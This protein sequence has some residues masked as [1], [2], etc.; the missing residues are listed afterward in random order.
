[1][2]GSLTIGRLL[3][4]YLQGTK[5]LR[6]GL[7]ETVLE[8]GSDGYPWILYESKKRLRGSLVLIHG[9]TAQASEDP[10][11][12]H[13]ARCLA[14]LGY[15]CLTPPLSR[16]AQF[17]HSEQDV[18]VVTLALSRARELAQAPVGV[19]AFSYGASY[20]LSAAARP[21]SRE[22]CRA[23]VAFGAYYLLA[24]ALEHQRQLLLQNPDPA[25]DDADLLYLR[26]T[27]LVCQ[28][29]DINLSG[30]AWEAIDQALADYT[31]LTTLA[32]KQRPLLQY[33]RDFDYVELM[34]RYQRRALA[35]ELSPAGRLHQIACPVALL[36]DPKDRF[37][38]PSHVDRIR[39]ELDSRPGVAVARTLTTPLLSHVQVD[40]MHNLRD[41]WRL[42]RLL[43][44]VFGFR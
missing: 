4:D 7:S 26:Y 35:A 12:V 18:D 19:L 44:P 2:L 27:L 30:Q 36:H 15:R 22:C 9:V 21:E 39:T 16:L 20:A 3:W 41:A 17:E 31:S 32:L 40:P 5:G 28:R 13:L 34:E 33:A 8:R 23:I 29:S 25:G 24:E 11:L 10:H 37:V 42:I 14:A 38:P 6:P 43:E 1:M